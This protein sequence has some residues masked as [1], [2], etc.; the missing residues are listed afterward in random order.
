MSSIPLAEAP[1]S[2]EHSTRIFFFVH[3]CDE[4]PR[5]VL[6]GLR[7]WLRLLKPDVLVAARSHLD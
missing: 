2:F 3:R 7:P 6:N 5:Q 1:I 4:I